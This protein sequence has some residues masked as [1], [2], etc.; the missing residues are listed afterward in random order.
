MTYDEPL[1]CNM[2]AADSILV[3]VNPASVGDTPR[4]YLGR[5]CRVV[6]T[7]QRLRLTTVAVFDY[8]QYCE[9]QLQVNSNCVEKLK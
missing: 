9:V 4:K 7:N 5:E 2:Q 3:S 6:E 8:K 1:E